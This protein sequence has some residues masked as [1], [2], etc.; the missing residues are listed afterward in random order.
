[1]RKTSKN[2]LT[3]FICNSF[4][5]L[6][7]NLKLGGE[8]HLV[9]RHICLSG[10]KC[11]TFETRSMTNTIAKQWEAAPQV[12]RQTLCVWWKTTAQCTDALLSV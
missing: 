5:C 8:S 6:S 9:E 7:L 2:V 10:T 3:R 11:L 1:M 4:P 12:C